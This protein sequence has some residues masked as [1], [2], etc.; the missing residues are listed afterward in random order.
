MKNVNA[1]IG[2]LVIASEGNDLFLKGS[3][4]SISSAHLNTLENSPS[5]NITI[6]VDYSGSGEGTVS[7]VYKN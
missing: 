7:S 6:T 5:K 2:A 1:L 3:W 4:N